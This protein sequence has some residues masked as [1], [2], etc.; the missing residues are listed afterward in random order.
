MQVPQGINLL[1]GRLLQDMV[2]HNLRAK[3][4]ATLAVKRVTRHTDEGMSIDCS[5]HKDSKKS[6]D[7]ATVHID[8]QYQ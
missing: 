3:S 2:Q 8:L 5:N 7:L 1:N 4:E 6:K